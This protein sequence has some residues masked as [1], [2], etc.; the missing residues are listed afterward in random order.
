VVRKERARSVFCVKTCD[1]YS[2]GLAGGLPRFQNVF[3]F[4]FLSDL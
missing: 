1:D 3:F 2:E 4:A